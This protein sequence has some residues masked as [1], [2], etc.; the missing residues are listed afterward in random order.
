[1]NPI[2]NIN[3]KKNNLLWLLGIL[4]LTFIA[5][6]PVFQNNFLS[7]WDDNRY[8]LENPLIKSL[9]FQNIINIFTQYYDGHY[10][11]LTQLSLAIDYQIAGLEPWIFHFTNFLLHLI[12]TALVFYFIYILFKKPVIAIITALL[13]GINPMQVESVAWITE[14][15]NLLFAIFFFGSLISYVKYIKLEK[16][17]Y[18]YISLLLFLL[19][20][21]SKVM[22][23]SLSV[24]IIAID[25]ALNRKLLSKKVIIEKIPFFLLAIIFGIFAIF[26]QKSTWG[27]ELSQNYY[28][29]FERLLFASYAFIHYILKLIIPVNLSGYY[30]YPDISNN[31]IP[32]Q[33]WLYPIPVISIILAFIYSLKRS[34]ILSFAMLFYIINIFLLLKL[35]EVP[36]G[37]Y[38][39]ADRYSYIASV[40][41]F[42]LIGIG[43]NYII[44]NK[45]QLKKILQIILIVYV[46]FLC[47]QTFNRTIIW[48]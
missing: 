11:P 43:F 19:S 10:H 18:Y 48:R 22:A 14:R 36:A 25:F 28:T 38:I 3:I 20:V 15:K 46:L 9:S 21:L 5:Y 8:V 6:F 44:N 32:F 4:V 35:F 7:T 37:D 24:T 13:F 23:I 42:I 47:L 1:M 17:K 12:N 31:S 2:K 45:Q 40:G 16:R 29:F 34:R 33:Y 39:M 30:P 27:E 41:V 26:A